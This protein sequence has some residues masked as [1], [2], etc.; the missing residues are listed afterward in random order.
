[1]FELNLIPHMTL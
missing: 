1:M